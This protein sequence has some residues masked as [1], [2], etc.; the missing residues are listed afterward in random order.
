MRGERRV[1]GYMLWGNAARATQRLMASLEIIRDKEARSWHVPR[2]LSRL[3][4]I[5]EICER[6]EENTYV[7]G[8]LHSTDVDLYNLT[9]MLRSPARAILCDGRV[10]DDGLFLGESFRGILMRHS[11]TNGRVLVETSSSMTNQ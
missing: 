1:R 10:L 9:D 2:C 8:I 5:R 4:Y 7:L 3:L 6:G 11:Q